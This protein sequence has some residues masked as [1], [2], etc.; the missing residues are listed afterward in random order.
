MDLTGL[1]REEL[2]EISKAL[3]EARK[4]LPP[5]PKMRFDTAEVDGESVRRLRVKR[6]GR[7]QPTAL[8]RAQV[9]LILDNAEGLREWCE[10]GIEPESFNE[11]DDGDDSES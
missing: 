1:T 9:R 4:S 7:G 2:R 10:F 6:D 3:A 8:D 11:G 5:A